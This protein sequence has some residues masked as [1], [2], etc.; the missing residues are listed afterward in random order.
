MKRKYFAVTAVLAA[1]LAMSTVGSAEEA[2]KY[3]YTTLN[4]PYADF[5]YGELNDI[6]AEEPGTAVKGQYDA[7]DAV[8][9]AGYR[10]EGIYDAVTSATTQKST[11]FGGAYTEEAGEGINILG[12]ANVNVAISEQLY[13]D[14][15]AALENGT[16]CSNPLL[17]LVSQIEEVSEAAP[18]EYKVLNSDGTLSKTVGNTVA[19]EDAAA[20]ITTI[21]RWGNYQISIEGIEV[22]ADAMQGAILETSDGSRYGLEHEDNLWLQP[23]EIAIAV[24]A[25]TEPHGN[26]VAYQR[27]SDIQGKTITKITYLLANAD[28]I[29]ISTEL[30]CKTLLGEGEGLTAPEEVSYST[31]GTAITL[32]MA[33]PDGT[34]YALSS[35]EGNSVL[36]EG[37]YTLEGDVLTLG[38]EN[39]PGSYTITYSDENY[40]DAQA[41]VLVT[42]NLEEGSITIEE[43]AVVVAENEDGVT[44]SDFVANVSSVLVNG[45]AAG[46][47]NPGM[48]IFNEDGSINMDAELS[49]RDG[50]TTPIFD[51][52]GEFA[53]EITANGYPTVSGTVTK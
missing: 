18:A 22:E 7:A 15:K 39:K 4:I 48:V 28:D 3:V 49:G 24:E 45:E 9:E 41:T 19:A 5:Y 43:N 25:F 26:E 34:A 35:V 32:E 47:K 6:E 11:A 31:D 23:A 53:I 14:A 30:L 27:F 51:G 13:E 50:S 21:S 10:E 37:S 44:A 36:E 46:G 42:S 12:V 38:A 40:A 1:G 52:E 20:A 29:E 33:A 17:D 8:T 2:D 16:A